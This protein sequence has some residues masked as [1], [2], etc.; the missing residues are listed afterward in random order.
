MD[1]LVFKPITYMHHRERWTTTTKEN[2][3]F[4]ITK[5]KY[6]NKFKVTLYKT[7]TQSLY[8]KQGFEDATVNSMEMA[9]KIANFVYNELRE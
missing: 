3:I 5:D 2:W 1:K 4:E 7:G 8:D 9:E 6:Y